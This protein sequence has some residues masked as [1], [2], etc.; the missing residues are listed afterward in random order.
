MIAGV[1]TRHTF[2]G[3]RVPTPASVARTSYGTLEF[4]IL[5]PF[6]LIIA[7]VYAVTIVLWLIA[8]VLWTVTWPLHRGRI[9]PRR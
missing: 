4:L 3:G 9:G 2:A 8:A 7:V 6:W 1:N 5:L